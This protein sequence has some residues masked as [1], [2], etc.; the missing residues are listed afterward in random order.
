MSEKKRVWLVFAVVIYFV[1][2]FGATRPIPQETVLVPR[3]LS[4][5]ESGGSITPDGNTVLSDAIE[6]DG[7]AVGRLLPFSLGS[8][9]GYVDK[10]G[11]FAVNQIKKANVSLSYDRWVEYEAEPEKIE[12]RAVNG[13]PL[14][15]IENPRGYPFFLDGRTFIVGNE[16]NAISEIDD[17]GTVL[18][19]YE[20]A[21]PLTCIDS[22]AGL[23]LA[24]LLDGTAVVL[25]RR[26]RQV[27]SF[28]PGGSRY[29]IILGCA[30]SRDGSRIGIISGIET[31]R[32]LLLERFGTS[33]IF[34]GGASSENI[35]YKPAYHEFL[36]DGFRRPV[37]IEFVENDRWIVF[38]R[39]GGLG[40]YE[41]GSRQS[42]KIEL[43]GEICTLDTTGGSGIVFAIITLSGNEKE[44]VGIKL[45]GR[46]VLKAPFKSWDFFIGRMDS[47]LLVG[48]GQTLVSFVLEKR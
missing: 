35:D 28:A 30:I 6:A 18:W 4:S 1:Y 37:H 27:F 22:A 40:F 15:V 46:T 34:A 10:D 43:N 42:S 5:L 33:G 19:T 23:V 47:E 29:A 25:D 45:P 20:F 31:Q 36:E 24:G 16:Q 41:T 48:G 14:T 17:S 32:F 2:F 44:L 38:E 21:G 8:R 7:E 9:F 3:W 13:N 11:R 26:G 12:I 39:E